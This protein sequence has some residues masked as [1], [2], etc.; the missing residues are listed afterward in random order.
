MNP[1]IVTAIQIHIPEH[2]MLHGGVNNGR[3]ILP[4]ALQLPTRAELLLGAVPSPGQR[5]GSH[6]GCVSPHTRQM[7]R[8]AAI[9]EKRS[10][11]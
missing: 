5:E 10:Q 2:R 7:Q 6:G 1:S 3:S 11:A 9:C 8:C 4:G